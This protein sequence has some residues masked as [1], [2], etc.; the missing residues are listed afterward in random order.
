MALYKHQSQYLS[1][2]VSVC[3]LFMSRMTCD[4]GVI[5]QCRSK[6]TKQKISLHESVARA[7]QI[8]RLYSVPHTVWKRDLGLIGDMRAYEE[9]GK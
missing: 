3:R 6:R 9:G 2:W 1:N 7:K 5:H 4:E 8:V